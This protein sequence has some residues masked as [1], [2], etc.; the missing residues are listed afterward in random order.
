MADDSTTDDHGEELATNLANWEERVP[1]HLVAYGTDEFVADPAAISGVVATDAEALRPHLP[2]GGIEGLELLHLQCHIGTDTLSWARLGATV[3]G[4]DFSPAALEAATALAERAGLPARFV[5][6]DAM[7]ASDV[8]HERFD[9]VY[10]SIGTITWLPDLG[11]WARSISRLLKPGGVFYLRDGHPM[12]YTL[13]ED[14]EDGEL[15]VRY[16]YFGTGTATRWDDAS[17]YADREARLHNETTFEWPHSIAEILT[18]LLSAGLT[19]VAFDEQRTLPWQALPSMIAVQPGDGTGE[20][21]LPTAP[22]RLPLT[23]TVI[24]RLDG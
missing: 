14:R 10:T 23:Y 9:V 2:E 5:E 15:V 8:V 22:E 7:H 11:A 12:L 16:P 21:V 20:W 4:V 3:T 6:A 17:D 18:S 19:I 1:L 24:C 13:D